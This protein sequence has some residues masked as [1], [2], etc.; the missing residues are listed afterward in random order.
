M[1]KHAH[2][3][4]QDILD[5]DLTLGMADLQSIYRK[6]WDEAR[7]LGVQ[8]EVDEILQ[9][10]HLSAMD[11][12]MRSTLAKLRGAAY[13]L[14]LENPDSETSKETLEWLKTPESGADVVE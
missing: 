12:A 13:T 3:I 10:H 6:L 8:A 5:A 9:T 1:N 2:R 7:T 14:A 11:R 4:A